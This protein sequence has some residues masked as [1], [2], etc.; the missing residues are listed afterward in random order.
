M[1]N[2]VPYS[3]VII[4]AHLMDKNGLLKKE[5]IDRVIKGTHLYTSGCANK[6]ILPGWENRSDSKIAIAHAMQQYIATH[7]NVNDSDILINTMSRDTVGDA[8]F[9]RLNFSHI[10]HGKEIAVV[11]SDYH[12]H[13]TQLIFDFIFHDFSKI[14][15]IGIKTKN[16]TEQQH[17][18]KNSLRAF[19]KTFENTK[20]GQIKEI[21]NAII[22][23]HPFYNGLIHPKLTSAEL[24]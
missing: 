2:K 5:S 10:L 21:Q 12:V 18:E 22:S 19:F 1:N 7:Y 23:K 24:P 16:S 13:R 9:T 8:F 20:K 11:T 6:I 17:H 15:V 4:L 3:A 14:T